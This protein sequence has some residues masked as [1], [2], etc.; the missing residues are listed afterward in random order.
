M[1]KRIVILGAGESGVGSAIL[2]ADK[3]FDVWVSDLGIIGD[4]Y[5]QMLNENGILWE[6]GQHTEALILN[7]DEI[8]KSPGIP[9][10]APIVKKAVEKGIPLISEIE[11]AG[12][13]NTARTICITG[14]NGKTTTTSL[15]WHILRQAG[16]NAGL[17]GNIG[18][19]FALQVAREQHDWYVIEL[20]SFQL[21]GIVSFR[22]D[23][24][25]LLNIT[26]D[27]LDRYNYDFQEYIDSKFRITLNLTPTDTFIYCADDPV[28]DQELKKRIINVRM[29]PFSLNGPRP[30]GGWTSKDSIVVNVNKEEM[31][32]EIGEL[33]LKGKHNI[34][35]SLAAAMAAR[36]ME[37]S[38]ESVRNS[39]KT[40]TNVEH[41][42]EPVLTIRNVQYINDSKAT[43]VNSVWYALE[44][45]DAPVV[46]IAGGVDKG[47]NYDELAELVKQK[48]KAL[49]CLGAD[50]TKLLDFF[51]QMTRVVDTHSMEEAV[52]AA[53]A[54]AEKGDV[55]LLSPACA[56]FDLFKNY[57]DRGRQFKECVKRL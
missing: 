26:P 4:T 2:A 24:A 29:L 15:I 41:R 16:I 52:R 46:W 34:Y 18:K 37:I 25:L 35:N 44:C 7:A 14:S 49:V 11:F 3:G 40:F 38:S 48:V 8:V 43:N 42:L 13:Y 21:D 12:R 47:N 19:S 10:K 28:I 36:V 20:S 17:A 57:E 22:P 51:G 50:N 1:K 53:Y 33:A 6:E 39:L 9:D 56:S 23:I 32:M 55:V 31:N 5:K 54:I 45:M 30:S 27:H